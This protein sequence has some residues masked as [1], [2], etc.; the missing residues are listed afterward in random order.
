MREMIASGRLA[1]ASAAVFALAGAVVLLMVVLHG[2]SESVTVPAQEVT[3]S[4]P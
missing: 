1:M 2:C 4:S 3:A